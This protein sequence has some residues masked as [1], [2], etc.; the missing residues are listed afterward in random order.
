MAIMGSM[1]RRLMIFLACDVVILIALGLT[2][3]LEDIARW[4]LDVVAYVLLTAW[5]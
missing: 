3:M 1:K 5:S 2:S 4:V